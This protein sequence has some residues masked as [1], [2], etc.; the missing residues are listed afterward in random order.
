[1]NQDTGVGPVCRVVREHAS[2]RDMINSEASLDE[3]RAQ[4]RGPTLFSEGMRLAEAGMTS[5][6]EVG[7]VAMSD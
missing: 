3:L 7:R 5:L 4:H 1:M 2:A 6:E